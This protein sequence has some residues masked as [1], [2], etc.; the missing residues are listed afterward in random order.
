M[1]QSPQYNQSRQSQG[2]TS[3]GNIFIRTWQLANKLF[4]E[5]FVPYLDNPFEEAISG[6]SQ[7]GAT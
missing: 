2:S 4:L 3:R 5:I 6:S 1:N 7:K